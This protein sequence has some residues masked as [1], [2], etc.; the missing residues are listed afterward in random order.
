MTAS[1]AKPIDM[2][3]RMIYRI[4]TQISEG[5]P[6]VIRTLMLKDDDTM[7]RVL[8][9]IV[10][11]PLDKLNFCEVHR[12][13]KKDNTVA[14]VIPCDKP[15]PT[16]VPIQT[17]HLSLRLKKESEEE[18]RNTLNTFFEGN[19][20]VPLTVPALPAPVV[21]EEKPPT[22]GTIPLKRYSTKVA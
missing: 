9:N 13:N 19:E 7:R 12:H 18:V 1:E 14:I 6:L 10:G 20:P 15:I 3:E 5:N 4:C 8:Q 2:Q 17:Y 16:G 22:P 11:C 21:Q